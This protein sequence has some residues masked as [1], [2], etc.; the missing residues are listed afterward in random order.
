MAMRFSHLPAPS[1]LTGEM[2]IGTSMCRER[3]SEALLTIEPSPRVRKG[4]PRGCSVP[5]C[6]GDT[7]RGRPVLRREESIARRGKCLPTIPA[8][9]RRFLYRCGA[10]ISA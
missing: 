10:G 4:N 2:T 6:S 1:A 7:G 8:A 3:S 9:R 5:P